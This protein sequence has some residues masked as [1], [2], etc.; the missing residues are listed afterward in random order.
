MDVEMV[1]KMVVLLA[2]QL[3][4]MMVEQ[5]ASWWVEY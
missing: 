5:M 3:A 4:H 1:V 2:G